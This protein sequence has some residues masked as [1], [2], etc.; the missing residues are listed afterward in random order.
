MPPAAKTKE[1]LLCRFW[2]KVDRGGGCWTWKGATLPSG[3]GRLTANQFQLYAHRFSYEIF[4]G[5]IPPGMVVRHS[6]DNPSCVNP[7]HLELGTQRDNIQDAFRKERMARGNMLPQAKVTPRAVRLMRRIRV[8]T[9]L[10]YTK[11]GPLFGISATQARR[12]CNR[13]DWRHI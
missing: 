10:Y 8:E 13:V 2:S 7:A 5:S 11:L 4:Y 6:C 3:H 12:I 9:G 1:E